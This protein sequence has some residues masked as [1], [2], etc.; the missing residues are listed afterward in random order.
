MSS[1]VPAEIPV[2]RAVRYAIHSDGATCTTNAA[3][4]SVPRP[5][6]PATPQAAASA[7]TQA[8]RATAERGFT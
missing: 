2:G 1:Q 6:R 5:A 3:V 7:A 4:S 8:A